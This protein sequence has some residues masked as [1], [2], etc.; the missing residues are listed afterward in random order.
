ML[1]FDTNRVLRLVETET[2]RILAQLESPDSCQVGSTT[3]SPDGSRLVFSS[4]DGPAV[5]VWDLRRIRRRLVEMGLDWDAPPFPETD[6]AAESSRSFSNIVVDPGPYKAELLPLLAQAAQLQHSGDVGGAIDRLGEAV[7]VSPDYGTAHNNL[8][9]LLLT[10][11][12]PQRNFDEAIRHARRAVELNRATRSASTR[13]ASRLSRTAVRR[14]DRDAREEPRRRKGRIGGI[15]PVLPGDRSPSIGP[16]RQARSGLRTEA[17]RHGRP[18]PIPGSRLLKELTGSLPEAE[19]VLG[20]AELPAGR[21]PRRNPVS[22]I[23]EALPFIE[24][25]LSRY[26]GLSTAPDQLLPTGGRW[27]PCSTFP[28]PSVW[29]SIVKVRS[30]PVNERTPS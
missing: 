20:S 4:N 7:R 29:S 15:R 6:P 16:R 24:R 1:V 19:A 17:K 30:L 18:S 28:V 3:F 26:A 5:H 10:A 11:P 23:L 12:R 25:E 14:R 9:W 13:S 21:L 27:H 22:P 2:G 8:A